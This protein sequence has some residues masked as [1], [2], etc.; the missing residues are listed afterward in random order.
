MGVTTPLFCP[1]TGRSRMAALLSPLCFGHKPSGEG[2]PRSFHLSGLATNRGVKERPRSFHPSVLATN[3]EV[4]LS[5]L[6]FGHKPRG[7]GRPR[8]F[9]PSVLATN[10]EVKEGCA[11]FT[12]GL[13][14]PSNAERRFCTEVWS[15]T[16][17]EFIHTRA[18]PSRHCSGSFSLSFVLFS[19]FRPPCFLIWSVMFFH[20]VC[21]FSAFPVS[22]F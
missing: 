18:S 14:N 10:R 2:R 6:C 13:G 4:L 15:P 19:E 9:H 12:S 5:P 1:Q 20:I 22:V 21:P 7:E 8:S 16:T 11:P 17:W 3:R